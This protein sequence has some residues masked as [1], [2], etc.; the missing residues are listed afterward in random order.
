MAKYLM[1]VESPTKAKK[2]A[3]FLGKDY[4]VIPSFGHV[5]D[6]PVKELGVDIKKDF[7]A[8]YVAEGDR[9]DVLKDIVFRAKKAQMVYLASERKYL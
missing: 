9:K 2:I 3:K 8:T 7:E 5:I 4:D 6:L 1:I